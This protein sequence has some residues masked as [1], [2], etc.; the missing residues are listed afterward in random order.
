M[1]LW[2]KTHAKLLFVCL[3][4][5]QQKR[6]TLWL[7]PKARDLVLCAFLYLHFCLWPLLQSSRKRS[8]YLLPLKLLKS[9]CR[10]RVVVDDETSHCA[11]CLKLTQTDKPAPNGG[12]WLH[13][14]C[15]QILRRCVAFLR[16]LLFKPDLPFGFTL[17]QRKDSFQLECTWSPRVPWPDPE[18]GPKGFLMLA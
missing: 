14:R 1:S 9:A 16:T 6:C 10:N 2:K 11:S 8:Y 5:S 18:A 15:I 3:Y 12:I 7:P 4:N 17:E 13:W